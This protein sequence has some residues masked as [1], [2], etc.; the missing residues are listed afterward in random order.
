MRQRLSIHNVHRQK[1]LFHRRVFIVTILITCLTLLLISRLI[2]LQIFQHAYY[3]TLSRDNSISLIPITPSRGLIYDRN[4][5]LIAENIPVFSLDVIPE[6]V[7]NLSQTIQQ[8]KK[9][10]HL[11]NRSIKLFYRQLHQKRK[12]DE[13]PL[14][15]KLTPTEVAKFSVN[16]YQ[17]PGVKI[18]ARL[19]RYYPENN[20]LVDILGYT[21]RI[22]QQELNQLNKSND[23][24]NNYIGTNYIGKLGIE[25]FF[26]P[27]LHG[28]VGY[29]QV[30]INSVGRIVRVLKK[31]PAI[32]G[33]TLHLTID[34]ALQKTAVK[35]MKDYRGAIIVLNPNNGNILAMASNPSYNPNLFVQGIS[36]KAFNHLRT[37][38][39]Q[40]LFNRTIR[41]QYPPGST[42]KPFFALQGLASKTVRAGFTI[43]DPGY[44]RINDHSRRY[45]DWKAH[46]QVNLIAAIE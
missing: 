29:Q 5:H 19:I 18:K 39:D 36:N 22:N 7:T 13:I 45:R 24:N 28:Q 23:I 20:A 14:K 17:F 30:E 26:E 4:N 9:I 25:K 34:T 44:F 42:L 31:M 32:A 40:P 16:R 46:G 33:D 21:G 35:A 11:N 6:Q 1:Q 38:P 37:S 27:E 41:G 15:I 43:N 3:T 10:I 8:L 2:Y 12:S